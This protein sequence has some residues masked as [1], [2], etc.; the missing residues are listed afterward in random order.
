MSSRERNYHKL[1][2]SDIFIS[3]YYNRAKIYVCNYNQNINKTIIA[4]KAVFNDHIH[5]FKLM[6]NYGLDIRRNSK[7]FLRDACEKG[8][9]N[10]A[11]YL[12]DIHHE[13]V[14]FDYLYL[15]VYGKNVKLLQFLLQ[16]NIPKRI[17]NSYPLKVA[18]RIGRIKMVKILIEY[19]FNP[20]ADSETP[21]SWAIQNGN[22]DIV[23]YLIR[24]GANPHHNNDELIIHARVI[25]L[26]QIAEVLENYITTKK[27]I[28]LKI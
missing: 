7:I 5:L 8:R 24:M 2:E 23:K 25:G 11:K 19:G 16:I 27:V 10:I 4:E 22:I 14:V 3:G 18:C 12:F 15:A 13:F 1:Y 9:F 17:L 28:V 21:L 26:T 20:N 6:V